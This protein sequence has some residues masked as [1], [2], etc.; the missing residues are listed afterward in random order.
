M[1]MSHQHQGLQGLPLP[2]QLLPQAFSLNAGFRGTGLGA[3]SRT[4]PRY[5]QVNV[6]NAG[7]LKI[8]FGQVQASVDTSMGT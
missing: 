3:D 7:P 8:E 2:P 6:Y 4:T 1:Q 5:D